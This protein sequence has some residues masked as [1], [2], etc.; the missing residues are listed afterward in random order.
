MIN[1][2]VY[3]VQVDEIA[4]QKVII[5]NVL[6]KGNIKGQFAVATVDPL[7]GSTIKESTQ[8]IGD[9]D[10]DAPTPFNVPVEST[11]GQLS[12]DQKVL[13]TLTYTDTLLQDHTITQVDT[14]SFGTPAL[15]SNL[16]FSQLPLVILVVV[17]GGIGGFVF[18]IKKKTK[19]PVAKTQQI[20]K[21]AS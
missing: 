14:V 6:N 13:V 5:G 21:T 11:T 1:V 9:I 12:G 19:E 8:Y 18:K 20:G 10:I 2:S 7:E 15:Q 4:G 3:G 16:N 17:A